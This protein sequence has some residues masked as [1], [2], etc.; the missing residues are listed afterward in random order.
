MAE[1]S[2][3]KLWKSEFYNNVSAIDR[4][5]DFNLNQLKLIVSDNYEKDE[6]VGEIFTPSNVED[7]LNKAYLDE[8]LSG[9]EG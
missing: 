3:D 4:G 6:K 8:K 9:K 7:V 1:I 5:Q 2:Y